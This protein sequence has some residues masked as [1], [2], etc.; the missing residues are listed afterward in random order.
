MSLIK[1]ITTFVSTFLPKLS[2]QEPKYPPD[3]IILDI[4]AS[5]SFVF[6]DIFWTKA[7]L[8]VVV[9]L[10]VRNNLCGDSSS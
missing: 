6:V 10:V 7:L 9:C 4:W 8:I 1:G 2:N 3:S 5:L